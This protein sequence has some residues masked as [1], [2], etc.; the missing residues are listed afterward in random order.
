MSSICPTLMTA[1]MRN[2]RSP[3]RKC[4]LGIL[5]QTFSN[6]LHLLPACGPRKQKANLRYFAHAL[7]P[8]QN[9]RSGGERAGAGHP[10]TRFLMMCAITGGHTA[11]PMSLIRSLWVPTRNT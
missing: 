3:V 9:P 5:S 4:K 7:M 8:D 1:S 2:I 11:L 10:F 6:F